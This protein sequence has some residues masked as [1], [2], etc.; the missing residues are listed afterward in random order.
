MPHSLRFLFN[1]HVGSLSAHSSAPPPFKDSTPI[2][3]NPLLHTSTCVLLHPVSIYLSISLLPAHYLRTYFSYPKKKDLILI[4][5]AYT[6]LDPSLLTTLPTFYLSTTFSMSVSTLSLS[7][8][9]ALSQSHHH[10]LTVHHHL[11]P[12]PTPPSI[13]DARTIN[14]L[15]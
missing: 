13:T 10:T 7:L 12:A 1:L 3:H 8:N 4:S 15:Q 11:R 5:P 6:Y 9:I 14:S 2:L